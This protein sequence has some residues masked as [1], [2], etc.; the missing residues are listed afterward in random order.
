MPIS[1]I[2]GCSAEHWNEVKTIITEAVESHANP[3][4]KVRLVSEAD[5]IG[6]IQKRIVQNVY[7][8][9]VVICDVS[10]KNPNVMF[11]L[12]LR[13]AFDK[14]T[15][16]IKDDKTDYSFDTG[17]IEHIP[18][19]RD[20]RF[21]RMVAFRTALV[22]KVIAT[23]QAAKTQGSKYSMFLKNFG[24]FQV[25][26]LEQTS[27]TPDALLVEAVRDLQQD[28]QRMRQEFVRS[29]SSL[30][31][32]RISTDG[33]RNEFL[34]TA[35]RAVVAKLKSD[36]NRGSTF[37]DLHAALITDFPQAKEFPIDEVFVA[38]DR[39]IKSPG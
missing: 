33:I 37:S 1:A 2:D 24:T 12:G 34:A 7:A 8:S 15:V 16:L 19:P 21:A 6:V 13:L 11:E 22:E 27:V 18:Y 17:V 39:A 29:G 20:L 26:N 14:A 10:G 30:K 9:D 38:I 4:F 32:A 31:A 5:D 35:A 28:V 23:H 3:C 25:A 36:P